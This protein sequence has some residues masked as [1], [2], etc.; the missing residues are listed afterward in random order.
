[1]AAKSHALVERAIEIL[2]SKPDGV[3]YSDLAK[4]LAAEF[5]DIKIATIRS[6]IWNIHTKNSEAV[7][8]PRHGVFRHTK[9]RSAEV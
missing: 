3:R 5:P 6:S 7:Y 2:R 1:L 4:V 8:K 9:F